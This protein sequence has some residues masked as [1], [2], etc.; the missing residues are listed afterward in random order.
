VRG[1]D[2]LDNT[3]RQ[4]FL[5]RLLGLP[6]PNYLHVPLVLNASGEK[7]SKQ[8]DAKSLNAEQPVMELQRAAQHLGLGTIE[9]ASVDAFLKKAAQ[10]WRAKS[11]VV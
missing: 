2:L 8:T 9:A 5:Q 11:D 3:P 1:A 4:I 6:T 7:L 10:R